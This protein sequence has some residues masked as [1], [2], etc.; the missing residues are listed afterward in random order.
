M[1]MFLLG[2]LVTIVL[3]IAANLLMPGVKPLWATVVYGAG[4]AWSRRLG[5]T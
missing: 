1:L 4:A 5:K 3:G 2:S